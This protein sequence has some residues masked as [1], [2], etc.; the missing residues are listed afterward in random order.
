MPKGGVLHHFEGVL[1]S[2]KSIAR[3]GALPPGPKIEKIQSQKVALKKKLSIRSEISIENGI[4][5]LGPLLAAE[6]QGLGL[7]F[8]NENETL[9]F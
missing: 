1:T 6:Q 7:K 9:K 8:S 2:L 4:F 3:Y 5:N